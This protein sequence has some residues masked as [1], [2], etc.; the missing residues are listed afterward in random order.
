MRLFP[1]IALLV[2]MIFSLAACQGETGPAGMQGPP[3]PQGIAGNAGP[4]GPQGPE[5]PQG[6]V[7][8]EGTA[9]APGP[10]GQSGPAGQRGPA[11]PAGATG[12]VG[13]AGKAMPMDVKPAKA[14]PPAPPRWNPEDY[15][16]YFVKEAIRMY[17]SEGLEATAAYYSRPESTDGQ[18]YMFITDENEIMVGHANPDLVGKNVNDIA[19]ANGYPS[20]SVAFTVANEEGAWFD[21]T[22]LNLSTGALE[23]KH[24]WVVR[25]D[26]IMF[27]SGWYEAGPSRADS[28]AFTKAF[29]RQ[30]INLY[31]A[32]GLEAVV[33]YYN[34]PE[35][36][37]G[38]W[39]VFVV[40]RNETLVTHADPAQ[41]GKNINDVLGPHGYPA[42][43]S[44]YAVADDDGAWF[45]Y[46][47]TNPATG[48]VETKH[49]WMV[50]HDGV[51]FGSGWYERGPS[52][53][54]AP[55]YTRTVVQQAISLY[56]AIG[57]DD[58]LAYYNTRES[59]DGQW[60]A[61]IVDAATGVTVGHPN[62]ALRDRDPSLRVD[63]TGYF[64]GDDLLSATESGSWSSYVIVN[65][66]TGEYQRKHTFAA[67]HDGYI[68]ASGWYE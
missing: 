37:D 41:V 45:S 44:V 58:T 35:S 30:A 8:P 2:V 39:Y 48:A 26:G 57:L 22:F 21:H 51:V 1:A 4:A 49:S 18:W 19:G 12:P 66:D 5:G 53:T 6:A 55:A 61:F 60:Y 23:T 24:S 9:G 50:L 64:Y 67:L 34:T 10:S 56:N 33:E 43:S 52:K 20:G 36:V 54:D 28:P 40:D 13:P 14:E 11:G 62:P 17:E 59:V 3:G 29:V 42:G 31:N 46:T 7:G 32:L 63:A 25:H 65:P 15:T 16:R 68:F 27:G 38:Q 47:F